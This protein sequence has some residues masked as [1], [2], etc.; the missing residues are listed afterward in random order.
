MKLYLRGLVGRLVGC[1][2]GH[3]VSPIHGTLLFRRRRRVVPFFEA[4]EMENVCTL[5]PNQRA[6][7]ARDLARRTAA[8][9]GHSTD[10]TEIVQIVRVLFSIFFPNVPLPMSDGMPMFYRYF[11][12]SCY[13]HW[14][15][16]V[17][18]LCGPEHSSC[19]SC[20]KSFVRL[21][22]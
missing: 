9:I 13:I 17:F 18:F 21:G 19:K 20:K 6:I 3:P 16:D 11:H 5:A 8:I 2:G 10:P 1:S 4:M 22:C 7:I 15:R 14:H 12:L